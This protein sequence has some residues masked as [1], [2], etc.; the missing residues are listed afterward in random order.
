MRPTPLLLNIE[1]ITLTLALVALLLIA[2]RTAVQKT[3]SN[4][5]IITFAALGLG[6]WLLLTAG[7]ASTTFLWQLDA[8]PPRIFLLVAP[9]LFGLVIF[10]RSKKVLELLNA[11]SPAWIVG[12]Q[13]F[14]VAMEIILWQL[15]LAGI[16][17]VQMTFEGRNFDI[18]VG[19][20]APIVAWLM[21][22]KRISRTALI[23]WNLVSLLILLNIVVV[24]VLS[25]PVPFRVFMN[26][27][28]NTVILSFPFVWLPTVVVPI[29]FLG[30]IASLRM[31][32][33]DKV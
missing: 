33:S 20:T 29:A 15:F 32:S 10:V 22:R 2:V 24:A 16:I 4:P 13:A 1:F 11:L 19:L 7:V 28:A 9:T 23:A 18:L 26:E 27:P 17:P 8:K 25:T 6:F 30:H 12:F 21:V 5:R 31:L 3:N 14:R